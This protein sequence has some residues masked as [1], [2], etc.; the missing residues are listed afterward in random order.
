MADCCT[1]RYLKNDTS[2]KSDFLIYGSYFLR[3][4]FLCTRLKLNS[5]YYTLIYI[6]GSFSL[7]QL[8]TMI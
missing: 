6:H 2:S 4:I 5:E 1:Y 7:T 8:F 3:Q